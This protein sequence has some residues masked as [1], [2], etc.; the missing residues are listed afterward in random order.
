MKFVR[1]ALHTVKKVTVIV[2]IN[3]IYCR[4]ELERKLLNQIVHVTDDIKP[5]VSL[6]VRQGKIKFF[7]HT[8]RK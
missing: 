1:K 6:L 5:L 4:G 7:Y 3:L 8:S 2:Q